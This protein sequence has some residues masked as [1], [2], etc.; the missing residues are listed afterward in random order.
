MRCLLLIL[1]LSGLSSCRLLPVSTVPTLRLPHSPAI[2]IPGT[3]KDPA[4]TAAA[5]HRTSQP[6]E[7]LALCLLTLEGLAPF[8]SKAANRL[9][10]DMTGLAASIWPTAATTVS[11]GG[12]TWQVLPHPL[13]GIPITTAALS[14][15]TGPLRHFRRKGSGTPVLCGPITEPD[16][17]PGGLWFSRTATVHIAANTARLNLVD[18]ALAPEETAAE[19]TLPW[20]RMFSAASPLDRRK[21]PDVFRPGKN[22]NGAHIYRLTPWDP[23]KRILLLVHGFFDT[24]HMWRSVVND[25]MR[26][27][28]IARHYQPWVFSWPTGLPLLTAA[29]S[30]RR[31]LND[32]LATADPAGTSFAAQH[33]TIAGHSMGG[34]LARTMASSSGTSVWHALFTLPPDEL[35][36]DAADREALREACFFSA[37]PRVER[38]IF[39]C[40]P[41]Q[42]SGIASSII[43]SSLARLQDIPT[44]VAGPVVRLLTFHP[45]V[46]QPDLL[47]DAFQPLH[48]SIPDLRPNSPALRALRTLPL[49]TEHHSIIALRFPWPA[50]WNSDG[51]VSWQSA[52][53]PSARS[54]ILVRGGHQAYSSRRALLA[55]RHILAAPLH[56]PSRQP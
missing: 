19:W 41:H 47:S 21:L 18:P 32:A 40:V 17:F 56:P 8:Q 11:T 16:A 38:L 13:P 9:R 14:R 52:H 49:T 22:P 29:A 55:L 33:I 35:P 43:G 6:R 23:D 39:L 53:L 31:E 50:Q 1:L 37:D 2:R 54:E 26:H 3:P 28:E 34:L 12:R 27:P 4:T 46:L 42:G 30:L 10:S 51:A 15:P 44:S 25:L 7:K 20:A 48:A 36:A 24:P 45:H 5:A